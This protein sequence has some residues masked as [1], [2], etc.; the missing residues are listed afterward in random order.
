MRKHSTRVWRCINCQSVLCLACRNGNQQPNGVPPA[1]VLSSSGL[2][3]LP[4]ASAGS[5]SAG[6]PG[7]G[8]W[9]APGPCSPHAST[10]R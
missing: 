10:L 4:S 6:E 1:G 9:A 2:P 7:Q 8:F 5:Q 3:Q